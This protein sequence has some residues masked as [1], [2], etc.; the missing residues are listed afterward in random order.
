MRMGWEP[1][2]LAIEIANKDRDKRHNMGFPNQPALTG[3]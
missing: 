2:L 1:R 3:V